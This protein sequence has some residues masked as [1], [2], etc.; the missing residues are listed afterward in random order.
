[1]ISKEI[2]D[3]TPLE[4][5]ED[6]KLTVNVAGDSFVTVKY[7]GNKTEDYTAPA[8][9]SETS[10]LNVV[11][12]FEQGDKAPN[13]SLP[14]I[15][16]GQPT[17]GFG[18]YF[19]KPSLSGFVT[20]KGSYSFKEDC[21]CEEGTTERSS[22]IDSSSSSANILDSFVEFS[23]YVLMQP[24]GS[25][26]G[27]VYFP[28]FNLSGNYTGSAFANAGCPSEP[29]TPVNKQLNGILE[30]RPV[31]KAE[32]SGKTDLSKDTYLQGSVTLS[33]QSVNVLKRP[34]DGWQV[35]VTITIAWKLGFSA[36]ATK[37]SSLAAL[38]FVPS[39]L[40]VLSNPA[41]NLTEPFPWN[42]I[43]PAERA[44]RKPRC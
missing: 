18:Y 4:I 31:V 14:G 29:Q 7:N 42:Q 10:N 3:T 38:P 8:I 43:S 19:L 2:M 34:S 27:G 23:V 26:T 1:V 22:N 44:A 21:V 33:D 30:Q 35:P 24:D 32:F 39:V 36:A 41:Q 13:I 11:W 16:L 20:H 9:G 6:S 12:R 25:Y 15:I 17:P 5:K 28:N 37:S 40:P